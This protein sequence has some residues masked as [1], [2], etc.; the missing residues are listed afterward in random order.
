MEIRE[1]PAR[2]C[3]QKRAA[4]LVRTESLLRA[5]PFWVSRE[6]RNVVQEIAERLRVVGGTRV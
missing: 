1:L 6:L 5:N 3:R 4:D 2:M